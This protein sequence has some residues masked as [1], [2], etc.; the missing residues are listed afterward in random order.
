MR[1]SNNW[2]E[3]AFFMSTIKIL[4]FLRIEDKLVARKLL[5]KLNP[6]LVLNLLLPR[7]LS[8]NAKIGFFPPFKK[9]TIKVNRVSSIFLKLG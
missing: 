5:F 2:R 1:L 7:S 8:L 6:K 3:T 4:L 9:P